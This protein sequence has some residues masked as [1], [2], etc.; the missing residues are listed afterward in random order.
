M[1]PKPSHGSISNV[2]HCIDGVIRAFEETTKVVNQTFVLKP[3]SQFCIFLYLTFPIL[4]ILE[5][6]EWQL[7]KTFSIHQPYGIDDGILHLLSNVN[8]IYFL[9]KSEHFESSLFFRWLVLRQTGMTQNMTSFKACKPDS[10]TC[11]CV[12]SLWKPIYMGLEK[13]QLPLRCFRYGKSTLFILEDLNRNFMNASE[14]EMVGIFV[15]LFR[16]FAFIHFYLVSV[17]PQPLAHTES[18]S[19]KLFSKAR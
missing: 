11:E 14:F 19:Y 7:G 5:I 9:Q 12:H 10:E 17:P 16:S 13:G 18:G 15:E 3:A 8:D 4:E 6:L 1:N 2:R